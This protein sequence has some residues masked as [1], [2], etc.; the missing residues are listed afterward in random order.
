MTVPEILLSGN[1][2]KIKKWRKEKS[3]ENTKKLRP[4]LIEKVKN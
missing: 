3:L 1:H 2:L 4:D